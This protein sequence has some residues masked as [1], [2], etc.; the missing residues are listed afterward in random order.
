MTSPPA[1]AR[2]LGTGGIAIGFAKLFFLIAGYTVSIYLTRLVSPATYGDYNVLSQLITIPNMVLIQTLLFAVSRPMSAEFPAGLPSYDGLRRRGFRVALIAGGLV[3]AVL[4]LGAGPIA[5][6]FL[7]DPALAE[8]LR[9]VAPIPLI[10]AVYAVNV[11]TLNAIRRFQLQATLDIIMAASKAALIIGAAA[12][13]FGLAHILGGFTIASLLVLSL[14]VGFVII[15]RPSGSGGG[16]GPLPPMASFAAVLAIFTAGVYLLQ[17]YDLFVLKH[18]ATT[19]AMEDAVG[20]YSSAALIARV[21]YSMMAAVSLVMFPLIATLHAARDEAEISRHVGGTARISALLLAF[22]SSVC[23]SAAP[24]VQSLLFPAA[25]ASAAD[26]LR[27]LVW[28]LSGYSL[29]VTSAWIFNSAH[30]SRAAI[31][32]IAV[33]LLAV[34]GLSLV[35]APTHFTIGTAISVA[36]AG[37]LGAIVSL[38]ALARVFKARVSPLFLAKLATAAVMVEVVSRVWSPAGKLAILAKL[39]ALALVFVAVAVLTRAVQPAELRALRRRP[40]APTST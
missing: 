29:T 3:A 17:G 15:S 12:L 19:Q 4:F 35:L 16:T 21:P 40:A 33:P 6:M 37:G 5:R 39:A 25:Y 27:L 32:L 26:E 11:G 7:D 10:Y 22:M 8:P 18:L 14:S 38:V 13:G 31:G 1:R 36:I 20:F 2:G 23:A 34:A 30:R 9:I 28:G 24:E